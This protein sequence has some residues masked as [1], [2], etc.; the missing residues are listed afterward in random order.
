MRKL[1]QTA[2][3]GFIAS[4][5]LSPAGVALGLVA[6]SQIRRNGDRGRGFAIAAIAIGAFSFLATGA[7]V[8]A[9]VN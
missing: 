5:F 4:F 3:I 6:L 8:A 2:L 9:P 1:N 7:R